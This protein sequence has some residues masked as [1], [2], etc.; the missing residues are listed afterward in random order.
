L[1]GQHKKF[2]PSPPHKQPE[3]YSSHL[4]DKSIY[5]YIYQEGG[6][7]VGGKSI[8]TSKTKKQPMVDTAMREFKFKTWLRNILKNTQQPVTIALL[9]YQRTEKP[10]LLG[11]KQVMNILKEMEDFGE[12]TIHE[13]KVY[14]NSGK[15]HPAI[16]SETTPSNRVPTTE[17]PK[18]V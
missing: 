14:Y 11:P 17:T 2:P 12:I 5:I 15:A 9:K 4:S 3:A 10:F 6:G 7:G 8:Y 18:N 16:D 1:L 13:E